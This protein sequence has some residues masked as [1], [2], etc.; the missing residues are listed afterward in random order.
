MA[1]LRNAALC[2]TVSAAIVLVPFCFWA[3]YHITKQAVKN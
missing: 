1:P 2:L 3:G